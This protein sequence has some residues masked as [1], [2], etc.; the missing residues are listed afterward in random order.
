MVIVKNK[1]ALAKMRSA[2]H[3]LALVM[4]EAV[5][6]LI[7]PGATT[8]EIDS[9]I[10][11][12]MRELGLLPVCKG[13][14]GYKH[15]T[16]ISLNDVVIHGIPSQ[17]VVLKSGDF[18]K[19]DVAGSY[20]GYC[21]DMTRYFFVGQVSSQVREL[22]AVAQRALDTAIAEI[23]P[24]KHLFDISASIQRVVENAGFGI[25]KDFAGH[26]IG[27]RLHE[28][29]EVPNYGRAG[30]GLVLREGMTFAIEPMITQGGSEVKVTDDGWSVRTVDGS[31]S[32]HVEDTI[33]VVK[34]GVEVLTRLDGFV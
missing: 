6:G 2:G 11:N 22:A 32:A 20:K 1:L 8:L 14:A 7:V 24:G 9:F 26:G 19:I 25:V 16:C 31:L 34:D 4:K 33:A 28:D 12:K 21:A 30:Q 13:Y 15:A 3:L 5:P 18:V 23:K 17:K 10:E 29:P 27:K